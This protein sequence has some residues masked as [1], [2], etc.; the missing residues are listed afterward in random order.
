MPSCLVPSLY[1]SVYDL[2]NVAMQIHCTGEGGPEEQ[3]AVEE[4]AFEAGLGAAQLKHR[5]S[6]CS[7]TVHF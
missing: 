5:A 7:P 2:H 6:L 1:E 3:E 4:Q